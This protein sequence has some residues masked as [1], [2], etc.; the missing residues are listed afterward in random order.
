MKN[1]PYIVFVLFLIISCQQQYTREGAIYLYPAEKTMPFD[2]LISGMNLIYLEE[3]EDLLI[4]EMNKIMKNGSIYYLLDSDKS[5][6]L[7]AYDEDGNYVS[8]Y[9]ARG[10]GPG[11]YNSILDFDID[12]KSNEIAILC[13]PSK[14]IITD[15]QLSFKREI[16][17]DDDFYDRLAIIEGNVFLFSYYS[18]IIGK[19][20]SNGILLKKNPISNKLVSG[21]VFFPQRVFYKLSDKY[22]MQSPGDDIIYIEENGEWAEYL[23]LDYEKKASSTKLYTQKRADAI[24]FEEKIFHPLPYIRCFFE[25]KEKEYF[26]YLFGVLHYLNDGCNNFLFSELPGIG[27]LNYDNGHLYTWQYLSDFKLE[28]T[29]Q[30][31]T[32]HNIEIHTSG[33]NHKD[34]LDDGSILLIDYIIKK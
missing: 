15:L 10:G 28:D 32:L 29:I 12:I 6:S 33:V 25:F 27:S 8:K 34:E 20:D 30:N 23:S 16:S 14:L 24:T 22:L 2:S 13:A 7:F 9:Y 18:G 19:Y 4:G 3:T 11:E 17:L 26:V 5:Q 1:I 21:N 31:K